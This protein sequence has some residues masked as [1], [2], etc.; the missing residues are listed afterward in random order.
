MKWWS[1]SRVQR[2]EG[3]RQAVVGSFKCGVL[4]RNYF[5]EEKMAVTTSK[6]TYCINQGSKRV[7]GLY[8][9]CL[10]EYKSV[11][12]DWWT[13]LVS[14]LI[15]EAFQSVL[16]Y[17]PLALSPRKS[18]SG[19]IQSPRDTSRSPFCT[20]VKPETGSKMKEV[21]PVMS[22]RSWEWITFT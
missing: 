7:Q 16:A 3:S 8:T 15:F 12:G 20:T 9:L 4:T 6:F 14:F 5:K 21:Q 1:L 18:V 22:V 17:T 10:L 2:R 13:P 19:A 11:L